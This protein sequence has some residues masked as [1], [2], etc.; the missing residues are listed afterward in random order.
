MNNL[1]RRFVA[2]RYPDF[3]ERHIF[4]S[5]LRL[6][7]FVGFWLLVVLF[8]PDLLWVKPPIM[9]WISLT[10]MATTILYHF[11]LSNRQPYL[12]FYFE[13]I[14]DLTAHT[15]LIYITGGA[16]SHL[17]LLYILYAIAGGLFYNWQVACLISINAFIIY[18]G[19]ILAD[20]L[21]WVPPFPIELRGIQWIGPEGYAWLKNWTLLL[22]FLPFVIYGNGLASY[23]TKRRERALDARNRELLVLNR[24]S[25]S[26]RSV[27]KLQRVV[28]EILDNL[29]KAYG[30][31]ASFGLLVDNENDKLRLIAEQGEMTEAVSRQLGF[32]LSSI[33]LPLNDTTNPVYQAM[34]EERPLVWPDMSQVVVGC[35]PPVKPELIQAIQ[36]DLGFRTLIAVPMLAERRLVGALV[37]LS[38]KEDLTDEDVNAFMRYADQSALVLDNARLIETLR[39]KNIELERVSRVKSEFLATMSH[40]LRTPLTAIIGF[41]ELLMEEVLG[42]LNQDQRESLLEVL[43]NAENL[44]QLI[45]GLLDLAKIEAGKMEVNLGPTSL[46]DIVERV[47]RSV[48]P[49]IKKKGL[50]LEIQVPAEI[51]SVF[52][53]ERKIQ[54][55]LLNLVSNAIKFTKE[56]GKIEIGVRYYPSAE[57]IE[58][59][60]GIA[61]KDFAQGAFELYV[62]DTGIGIEEK[63]LEM[64]FES[65]RQVDSSSTRNYQ[66]TGLGLALSQQFVEMHHGLIRAESDY[67]KGSTFKILLPKGQFEGGRQPKKAFVNK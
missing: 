18:S 13:Q 23:F 63:D 8:Y 49:L 28:D 4:T 47:Q 46:V 51:P 1:I 21:G 34:K 57:G 42:N 50:V 60:P 25:S 53:D 40:E 36:A 65:F 59:W 33:F 6:I 19:F 55:T 14:A 35:V 62:S 66:G 22:V 7:V 43:S 54:Q 61:A 20:Q 29:T 58:G 10:F 45:N 52:A 41:S 3:S 67:G 12:L 37:G 26:I 32:P 38:T 5:K 17:Y 2:I 15:L 48:S 30:F 31:A 64:I 39:T 27:I 44:L 56:G 9:L 11:I 24:L 16:D